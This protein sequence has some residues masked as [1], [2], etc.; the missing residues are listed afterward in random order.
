M[1]E[2][3]SLSLITHME[4]KRGRVIL[5]ESDVFESGSFLLRIA[6]SDII[7]L[8]HLFFPGREHYEEPHPC[9][10]PGCSCRNFVVDYRI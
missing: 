4:Y 1:K 5:T 8:T 6:N 9:G 7:N 2:N 3:G 10:F